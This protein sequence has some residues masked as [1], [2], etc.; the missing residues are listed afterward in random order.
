MSFDEDNKVLT[1][2]YD[3]AT[4]KQIEGYPPDFNFNT[5]LTSFYAV[6]MHI[7]VDGWSEIYFNA[8]RS[9]NIN[10]ILAGFFFY[11]LY[12]FGKMVLY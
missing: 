10:P 4:G 8:A 5:F 7:A 3:F 6:F 12:I 1:D 11:S 9:P 2:D